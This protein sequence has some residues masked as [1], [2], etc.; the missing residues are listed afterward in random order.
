MGL[1]K[2]DP[3]N[4]SANIN[5]LMYKNT[6]HIIILSYSPLPFL[7]HT[8][9]FCGSIYKNKL[10][11]LL[12]VLLCENVLERESVH[13]AH[14]MCKCSISITGPSDKHFSHNTAHIH[15]DCNQMEGIQTK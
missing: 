9:H 7:P 12:L 11:Y 6:A 8:H 4:D 15:K 14:R 10:A 3:Q 13:G 5:T 2:A 1:T